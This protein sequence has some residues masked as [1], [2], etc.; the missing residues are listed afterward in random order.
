MGIFKDIAKLT[1]VGLV[2][3]LLKGGKKDSSQ[4]ESAD[5]L[6]EQETAKKRKQQLAAT[7]ALNPTGTLGAG[8]AQTTRSKVLGV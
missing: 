8:K 1:P 5:E 2:S 3:G 6:L 4:V 7:E